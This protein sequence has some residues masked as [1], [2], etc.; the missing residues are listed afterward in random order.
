MLYSEFRP[1]STR[2]TAILTAQQHLDA[3]VWK[4]MLLMRWLRR[5]RT[6]PVKECRVCLD[7][8]TENRIL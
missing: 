1:L 3:A 4:I 7:R 2:V 6:S 8:Q 5:A